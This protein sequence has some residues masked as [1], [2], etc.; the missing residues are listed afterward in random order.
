MILAYVF[1]CPWKQDPSPGSQAEPFSDKRP[2]P[3][4]R[5]N[6]S[7]RSDRSPEIVRAD[8]M[9]EFSGFARTLAENRHG[10]FGA[11]LSVFWRCS[12]YRRPG[13]P[14]KRKFRFLNHRPRNPPNRTARSPCSLRFRRSSPNVMRNG[15]RHARTSNRKDPSPRS[16]AS[17]LPAGWRRVPSL[18]IRFRITRNYLIREME[19]V[20]WSL[21]PKEIDTSRQFILKGKAMSPSLIPRS[22][23]TLTPWRIVPRSILMLS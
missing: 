11:W 5:R 12:R 4:V 21:L 18:P 3:P 20:P 14:K 7:K 15:S 17:M 9:G 10:S 23:L 6:R 2:N 1:H 8:P 16:R 19:T 22:V 13:Q